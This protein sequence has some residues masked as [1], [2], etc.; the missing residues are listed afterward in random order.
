MEAT[1][2]ASEIALTRASLTTGISQKVEDLLARHAA[3]THPCVTIAQDLFAILNEIT[4]SIAALQEPVGPQHES[5]AALKLSLEPATSFVEKEL[6]AILE[7]W[8][9]QTGTVHKTAEADDSPSSEDMKEE[10]LT[11]VC[12]VLEII[13]GKASSSLFRDAAVAVLQPCPELG[14]DAAVTF[15]LFGQFSLK[16]QSLETLLPVV[17]MEGVGPELRPCFAHVL[18]ISMSVFTCVPSAL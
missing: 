8:C 2:A 3:N 12:T 13:L 16:L 4:S 17:R 9:L 11:M 14:G 5:L 7:T 6:A 18:Q 10:R 1:K 15:A